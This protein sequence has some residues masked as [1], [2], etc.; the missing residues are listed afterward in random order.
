VSDQQVV[1]VFFFDG[2]KVQQ[3][4]WS[5]AKW[6][7]GDTGAGVPDAKIPNGP[8]GMIGFPT[9]VRLYYPIDEARKIVEVNG[10]GEW[11]VE[12]TQEVDYD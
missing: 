1:Q 7:V 3:V 11:S 4:R 6:T 5:N 12:T 10:P 2:T 9:T 8:L